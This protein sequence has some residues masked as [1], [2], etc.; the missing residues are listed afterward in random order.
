MNACITQF[1]IYGAE[2]IRDRT[3]QEDGHLIGRIRISRKLIE[4][5]VTVQQNLPWKWVQIDDNGL[6]D[7][8]YILNILRFIQLV[9]ALFYFLSPTDEILV[10]S[11]ACGSLTC[12]SIRNVITRV[13]FHIPKS[14]N[15][16]R[17]SIRTPQKFIP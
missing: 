16:F 1:S 12:P 14:C 8:P 17:N 5:K 3:D 15:Y 13:L 10:P 7:L 11:V 4:W 9:R 6:A 2:E